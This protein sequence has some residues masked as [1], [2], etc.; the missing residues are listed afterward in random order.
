MVVARSFDDVLTAMG[1][2]QCPQ[3]SKAEKA[4]S[5][6][7]HA[8]VQRYWLLFSS[9]GIMMSVQDQGSFVM[10]G[11]FVPHLSRFSHADHVAPTHSAYINQ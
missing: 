7:A 10:P 5:V 6:I 1:A 3:V 4:T 2:A 9:L 11:L 8:C